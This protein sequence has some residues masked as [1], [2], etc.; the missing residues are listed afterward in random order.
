[1]PNTDT[2]TLQQVSE[3][4]GYAPFLAL[5]MLHS[6]WYQHRQTWINSF[7]A[8]RSGQRMPVQASNYWQKTLTLTDFLYL[9]QALLVPLGQFAVGISAS[10]NDLDFGKLQPAPTLKQISQLQQVIDQI[11]QDRQQHIQ[12]KLCYD[13][14]FSTMLDC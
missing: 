1:M 10:S 9:S 6:E 7:Q 5:Q 2:A 3:L 14:I 13:K 11:W 4:S 8:V 12:D